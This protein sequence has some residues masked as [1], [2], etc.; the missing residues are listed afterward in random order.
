MSLASRVQYPLLARN[1]SCSSGVPGPPTAPRLG[2]CAAIVCG[3][4]LGPAA[5]MRVA[6]MIHSSATEVIV[7]P[8]TRPGAVPP[9]PSLKILEP[10]SSPFGTSVPMKPRP[11]AR[12]Y[13]Q[14]MLGFGH[15]SWLLGPYD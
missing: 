13:T 1:C 5:S 11:N 7:L 10:G 12:S 15:D 8:S 14:P 6:I 4:S 9:P 2:A 3:V